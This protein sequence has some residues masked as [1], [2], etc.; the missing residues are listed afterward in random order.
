MPCPVEGCG[1]IAQFQLD[2]TPSA[3]PFE[4]HDIIYGL[5]AEHPNHPGGVE[6]VVTT[7]P[8]VTD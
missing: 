8:P 7:D 3:D 5:S 6:S 2:K 4:R 1:Y